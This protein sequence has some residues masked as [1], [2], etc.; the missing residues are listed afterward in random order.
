MAVQPSRQQ[1]V[2]LRDLLEAAPWSSLKVKEVP[3]ST[4][5]YVQIRRDT[6]DSAP[7]AYNITRL[8]A[9]TRTS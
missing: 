8:G 4:D 5:V 6:A 7:E 3:N 9:T 2:A 1:T